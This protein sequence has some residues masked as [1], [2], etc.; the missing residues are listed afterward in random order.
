MSKREKPIGAEN[1]Q[2][3]AERFILD[4]YPYANVAF[5]RAALKT[6]GTRQVYE[7]A[8]YCRLARWLNS[9][10]RK[11]LCEIQVDAYSADIVGYHGM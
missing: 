8:G 3:V 11:S 1:A 4:R 2:R 9:T 7:L 6:C 10:D 5:G